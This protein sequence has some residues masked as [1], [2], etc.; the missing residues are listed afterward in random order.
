MPQR[1]SPRLRRLLEKRNELADRLG[2]EHS[3]IGSRAVVERALERVTS[4]ADPEQTPGLRRWQWE[5][6]GDDIRASAG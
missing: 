1:K 4:G 3:V 6:L 2:L 5:L